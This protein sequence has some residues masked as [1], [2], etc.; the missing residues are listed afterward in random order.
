MDSAR[1]LHVVMFPFFAFGHISPFIQLSNKLSSHGVQVSFFSAPGN[2]QRISLSL[3]TSLPHVQII[4]L[5]I[6]A[7]D[8]LPVGVESTAD[9]TPTMAEL[10]KKALDQMQPQVESVLADLKPHF[11]FHDFAQPWL[12]S[13]ADK[14]GI[15]SLFFSVFSALSSAYCTVPAR[16]PTGESP[17]LNDLKKPPPG[18]PSDFN[19]TMTT[20][21][22][23][24]MLYLF[25]IFHGNYSVY[26]RVVT[27]MKAC[28]AIVIKTCNEIEGPYIEYVKAQFGKPVLLLGPLIPNPPTGVLEEKW[29]EWLDQFPKKSVIFCSF[30]SETFLEDEQIKELVLGLA[31]TGLPFFVVLNFEANAKKRLA[32]ALPEG[33]EERLQGKGVVHTGWVQQQHILAH[34]NVGCFVCHSGLSSI[35]EAL[36]NDCQLVLLPQ[37]GDQFLNAKLVDEDMKAGVEVRTNDEN[38]SFKKE[39]IH[40]AVKTVMVDVDEEPGRT[41]R[42]NNDKWRK[43]MVDKEI[44]EGF[45][46]DFVKEMKEMA[47]G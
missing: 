23:R 44:H 16:K 42:A 46:K 32:S 47:L 30:G 29:A 11:V 1:E 10:L 34:D 19:K 14:L 3:N 15:K 7:V 4:P 2:I 37:K 45:V 35:T 17:T 22:A 31:S 21:Q 9:M 25:K 28:S 26:D 36:M 40:K 13:I 38:G 5:K 18:F 20:H 12:P 27:C 41:I 24:D 6:P 8:G 33:F 39:D 43:F